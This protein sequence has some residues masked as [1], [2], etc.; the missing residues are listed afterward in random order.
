MSTFFEYFFDTF[1][2]SE[3]MCSDKDIDYDFGDYDDS[4]DLHINE[5]DDDY[6]D[7][8]NFHDYSGEDDGDGAYRTS[9][10]RCS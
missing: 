1:G 3:P 5:N 4:V 6:G 8:N 7:S 10:L 2:H 9:L